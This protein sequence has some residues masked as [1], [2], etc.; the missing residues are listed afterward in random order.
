MVGLLG[1]IVSRYLSRCRSSIC[2][3][4]QIDRARER[5]RLDLNAR[6]RLRVPSSRVTL[7]GG[8]VAGNRG[9]QVL[10]V[11]SSPVCGGGLL[12]GLLVLHRI[13]HRNTASRK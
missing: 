10:P 7:A 4:L 3:P 12:F 11:R 1:S 13:G 2:A 6:R 9:R 8:A 5:G